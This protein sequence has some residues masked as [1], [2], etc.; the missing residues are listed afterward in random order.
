MRG[1]SA[2][3][4]L[5]LGLAGACGVRAPTTAVIIPAAPA[6]ASAASPSEP[7][8]VARPQL[9]T[10]GSRTCALRSDG[11]V[12][13]WGDTPGGVPATAHLVGVAR[14]TGIAFMNRDLLVR[15]YR[16]PG[17]IGS[18]S[19]EKP[20]SPAEG[21]EG[22]ASISCHGNA[23][24]AV[25]QGVVLCWGSNE[26]KR[27][28]IAGPDRPS[29]E[30]VPGVPPASSVVVG[31]EHAC[32]V[33]QSGDVHCWGS[34]QYSQL[35]DGTSLR[36]Y[37]PPGPVQQLHDVVELATDFRFTC[38]RRRNGEVRCWGDAISGSLG[39][40][41]RD[42]NTSV[43]VRGAPPAVAVSVSSSHGCILAGDGSVWCWGANEY[44]QVGDGTKTRAPSAV[45][46]RGIDDAIA[47]AVGRSFSCAMKR[48]ESVMCWGY[49]LDGKLGD[50]VTSEVWTPSVLQGAGNAVSLCEEVLGTCA[51]GADHRMRCWGYLSLPKLNDKLDVAACTNNCVLH[52]GGVVECLTPV[53][54]VDQ[55]VA[56]T[57]AGQGGCALRKDGTVVCWDSG[58]GRY[59]TMFKNATTIASGSRAACV[60]AQSGELWCWGDVTRHGFAGTRPIVPE[61]GRGVVAVSMDQAIEVPSAC[62]AYGDGTVACWYWGSHRDAG[63]AL[64]PARQAARRCHQ[65]GVSRGR[66]RARLRHPARRA[67]AVLG[68][69]RRRPAG[70]RNE[71]AAQGSS[72]GERVDRCDRSLRRA[73]LPLRR[74]TQ[75]RGAVLGRQSL[76]TAWL[77]AREDVARA[78]AGAGHSASRHRPPAICHADAAVV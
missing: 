68:P 20:F 32:A 39:T 16:G 33:L 49:R 74:E 35:G 76:R 75:R 12:Y 38:A 54:G 18:T 3:V 58:G 21:L 62:V 59:K 69:E 77:A 8:T 61:G 42:S 19:G 56:I 40:G 45:K 28:G 37:K 13:C 50:G 71:R 26:G 34:N 73:R 67:F 43:L 15:T 22:L 72:G 25:D 17:L 48:D 46:T 24:C 4:S 36:E 66:C 2:V 55:A 11:S 1:V 5:L 78:C 41:S 57:G 31:A 9:I 63:R 51:V 14:A 27:L 60:L 29:R 52:V 47:V 64:E 30:P 44:G 23:C 6:S 53:Q 10:L 65:C 7:E 70:R